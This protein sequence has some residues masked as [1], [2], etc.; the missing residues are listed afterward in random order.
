MAFAS[1]P[2]ASRRVRGLG[3]SPR[4]VLL[5]RSRFGGVAIARA[6]LNLPQC[7]VLRVGQF[8]EQAL[9]WCHLCALCAVRAQELGLPSRAALLAR[10]NKDLLHVRAF[11]SDFFLIPAFSFVNSELRNQR[12]CAPRA[13]ATA[14]HCSVPRRSLRSSALAQE[15]EPMPRRSLPAACT[16][17]RAGLPARTLPP[18]G[19]PRPRAG[20]R[21]RRTDRPP[22]RASRGRRDTFASP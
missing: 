15:E 12:P 20:R 10:A 9:M 13:R 18:P 21:L 14:H 7:P 4:S 19:R 22:R 1:P 6:A 8:R 5:T 17:S 16:Q 11:T 3:R 2:A